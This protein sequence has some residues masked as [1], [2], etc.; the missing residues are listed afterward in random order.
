[1][2]LTQLIKGCWLFFF[3]VSYNQSA[4]V[5]AL[6]NIQ[7]PLMLGDLV[8]VISNFTQE[9]AGN[10]LE[11]VR[12]PAQK[13]CLF[14]IIQVHIDAYLFILLKLSSSTKLCH[15]SL[16]IIHISTLPDSLLLNASIVRSLIVARVNMFMQK[17]K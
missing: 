6:V 4:V 11:L 7:I 15:F 16:C 5:V 9:N 3:P 1:M 8:N 13:L 14:Y 17:G 2:K 10:F 12:S